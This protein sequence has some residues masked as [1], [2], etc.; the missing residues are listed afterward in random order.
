LPLIGFI[1][2]L[3][4]L[5]TKSFFAVKNEKDVLPELFLYSKWVA[6]FILLAAVSSRLDTFISGRLLTESQI[7]IYG[8]ANQLVSVIPQIIGG[9]GAVMAPKFASYTNTSQMLTYLKKSQLLVV[10][11]AGVILISLPLANYLIPVLLSES[12]LDVVPVFNV[13]A[14]AMV[15]FLIAIPIHNAIIYYFSYPKLFT[16]LSFIDLVIVGGG[17]YYLISNYG[18]MG[19]AYT[20]LLTQLVNLIIPVGWFFYKLKK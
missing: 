5:P 10:G 2:A 13:L 8:S 16:I 3:F 9:L 4:I 15:V 18:L 6:L 12:Y 20:V 19:A 14:V 17:G 11:I 7:G 1:I